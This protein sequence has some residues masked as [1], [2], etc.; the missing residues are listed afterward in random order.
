MEFSNANGT[1]AN[2]VASHHGNT[3]ANRHGGFSRSGTRCAAVGVCEALTGRDYGQGVVRACISDALALFVL[4]VAA[5]DVSGAAR[6]FRWL[7]SSPSFWSADGSRLFFTRRTAS[8][9]ALTT[10]FDAY[11]VQADGT[12]IARVVPELPDG[13]YVRAAD[14]RPIAFVAAPDRGGGL[15]LVHPDGSHR[16]T[17]AER[18]VGDSVTVT[19]DGRRLAYAVG[20]SLKVAYVFVADVASGETGR[21]GTGFALRWSRDGTKLAI[22]D[23]DEVTV[24]DVNSQRVLFS[25][26]RY[27]FNPQLPVFSPTGERIAF[28]ADTRDGGHV[29]VVDLRSGSVHDFGLAGEVESWSP[30]GSM[31][32][33]HGAAGPGIGLVNSTTGERRR[34]LPDV[35]IFRFSPDWKRYAFSVHVLLGTDLYIGQTGSAR[36]R[37]VGRSQCAVVRVRCLA[38]G[39]ADERLRGGPRGDIILAGF[40]SD[41]VYGRGGNDRLEGEFG[42]DVLLAAAGNDHLLGGPGTDRLAGGTGRD[43]LRGGPG[44]DKLHGGGARDVIFGAEGRDLIV[45]GA[46]SD[47][48]SSD[49]DRAVDRISCGASFD[50]VRADRRD[51]VA[52]DCER[53]R[54]TWRG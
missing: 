52:A 16:R 51:K 13:R 10:G 53:V 48:L 21:V 19:P 1:P 2:L 54:R 12:G 24:L 41:A 5:A 39:S 15:S 27:G 4:T 31:L 37:R 45:G 40:G 43:T 30:D 6:S 22:E 9:S 7:E 26:A 23:D 28:T 20:V 32:A 14:G 18:V 46:G 11:V 47:S 3:N 44:D 38:G 36:P 25:S 29:F 49:G 42:A 17:L 34:F 33:V 8:A 50:Y 35:E